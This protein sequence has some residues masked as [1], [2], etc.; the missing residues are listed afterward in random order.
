[1][2]CHLMLSFLSTLPDKLNISQGSENLEELLGELEY[3][4]MS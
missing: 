2:L 4:R 3:G 1:M